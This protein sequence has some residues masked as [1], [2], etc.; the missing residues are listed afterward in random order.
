LYVSGDGN[1]R[2][3]LSVTGVVLKNSFP[4]P[5]RSPVQ[6]LRGIFSMKSSI[7][8]N[9]Q[10]Q[11]QGGGALYVNNGSDITLSRCSFSNNTLTAAIPAP[12]TDCGGL[13]DD[14]GNAQISN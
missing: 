4:F 3:S 9:N 5:P 7:V 12:D 13:F 14:G 8:F 2:P 10:T 1:P 11:G 6:V